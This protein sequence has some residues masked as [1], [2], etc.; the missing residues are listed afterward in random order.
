MYIVTENALVCFL[1]PSFVR[2]SIV[3]SYVGAGGVLRALLN[4]ISTFS[5]SPRSLG[6]R[7][8][9]GGTYCPHSISHLY[10]FEVAT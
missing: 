9:G 1:S 5:L 4:L 6:L 8:V 10:I 3:V 7:W 2:L